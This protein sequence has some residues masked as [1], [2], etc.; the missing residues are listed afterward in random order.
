MRML[1]QTLWFLDQ[2]MRT[3]E[4]VA[5]AE[6]MVE[7]GGEE[8]EEEGDGTRAGRYGITSERPCAHMAIKSILKLS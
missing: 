7:G 4:G 8:E 5:V 1:G 2:F 6:A 3:V